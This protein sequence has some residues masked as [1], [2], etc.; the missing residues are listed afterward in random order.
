VA[1]VVAFQE[2]SVS[3][4]SFFVL[5]PLVPPPYWL[6]E[7]QSLENPQIASYR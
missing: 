2:E 4:L 6:I 5:T 1:T 7:V 3:D